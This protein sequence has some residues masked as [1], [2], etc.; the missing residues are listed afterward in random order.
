V[1]TLHPQF[2]T[3]LPGGIFSDAQKVGT[4]SPQSGP[5]AETL[6]NRLSYSHREMI[7]DLDADAKR[8]FYA[9]ECLS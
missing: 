6:L 3:L 2:R 4:P 5:P 1:G 8:E 9:A 7:V